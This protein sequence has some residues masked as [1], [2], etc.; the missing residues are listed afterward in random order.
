[1]TVIGLDLGTRTIGIAISRTGIIANP[2]TLLKYD[3]D[4]YDY[5]ASEIKKIVEKENVSKIVLGFP[6][7]MNNTCGFATERTKKFQEVLE[8]YVN[9]PIILVDERLST[10][11]ATN[12]LLAN[13]MS[14]KKRKKI[15]DV[16]AAMIIL[17]T[18]LIKPS[19]A[20]GEE[21][22]F[23]PLYT[24]DSDETKKSYIV[25][26]DHEKDKDGKEKVY[27]SI[28]DSTGKDSNLYPIETEKEWNL[29]FNILESIQKKLEEEKNV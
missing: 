11:E 1:M 9:V 12:I 6:K 23:E 19:N 3:N 29:I 24:F 18:Y 15:I 27:A 16:T 22:E 21:K 10:V 14:R 2:Y 8:K 26:T 17:D 7:N 5:L 20:A 4:D 25:Y 28:Y 13:D